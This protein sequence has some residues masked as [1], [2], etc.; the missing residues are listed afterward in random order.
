[1]G[2]RDNNSVTVPFTTFGQAFNTGDRVGFFALTAKPGTDVPTLERE[3]RHALAARHRVDPEDDLAIGSFNAFVMFRKMTGFF[4]G[5]NLI[6]WVVGVATLLAGVIG[7][8]NIMLITVK[9]RTREFGLRKALGAKPF[10]IVAMV[11][12]EAVVLTAVAGLA[13]ITAGIGLDM[14][15]VWMLAKAGPSV[16]FGQPQLAFSTVLFAGGIL[17]AAG[18][19]AGVLPAIHAVRIKHVE[20][21]RAE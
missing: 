2:D 17:V 14:L 13:G 18:A 15:A 4:V 8:A 9:E 19:L 10:A 20:A 6:L 7:V 21:L 12:K 5:L 16:P 1:M 11:V 3:I